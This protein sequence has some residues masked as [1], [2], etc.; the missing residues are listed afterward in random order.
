[1]GYTVHMSNVVE[2]KRFGTRIARFGTAAGFIAAVNWAFDY[3]F[4]GWAIWHF[5]SFTGSMM[6]LVIALTLNY[7]IVQWYRKTTP[8]WFGMEWLR[9]QEAV[10]SDAW[11]GRVIR[12][13]LRKSRLMAFAAIAALADPVY[14]FIYQRGRLTGVRFTPHDWWWFGLAN[15]LGILPW[16]VGASIAVE[17]AKFTIQ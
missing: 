4:T 1:M 6:I 12:S 11:S 10:S 13:L 16:I 7:F 3:P 8:D 14:A 15:T 17:T 2:V 5:G 9:T